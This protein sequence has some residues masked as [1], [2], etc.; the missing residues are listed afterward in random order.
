MKKNTKMYM[1][2]LVFW[3]AAF[4][5]RID[6]GVKVH[7]RANDKGKAKAEPKTPDA[8]E[9]SHISQVFNSFFTRLD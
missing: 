5:Q 9:F 8:M 1:D 2:D 4:S 3:H 7:P 6:A